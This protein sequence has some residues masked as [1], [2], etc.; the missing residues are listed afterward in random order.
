MT[1]KDG[2]PYVIRSSYPEV[3]GVLIVAQGAASAVVR[4]Q[5]LSAASTLLGLSYQQIQVA[6]YQS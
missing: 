3:K 6:T 2:N 5:L 1:D 4:E